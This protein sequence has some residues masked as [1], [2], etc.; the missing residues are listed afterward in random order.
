MQKHTKVLLLLLPLVLAKVPNTVPN[1]E[2]DAATV[3]EKQGSKLNL[4]YYN[5]EAVV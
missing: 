2:A 1:E 4:F 3:N 5:S